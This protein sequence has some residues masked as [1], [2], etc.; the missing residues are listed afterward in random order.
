MPISTAPATIAVVE[1]AIAGARE[2]ADFVIFSIHWSPHMRER[3]TLE[4]RE[5]ARRI[6]DAGA[7]LVWGHGSHVVQ[8]IELWHGNPILY[9]TGDF[10]DDYAVDP[11]LRTD[12]SALF[13]VRVAPSA[14]ARIEVL[15]VR[16]ADGQVNRACGRDRNW[17]ARRF[18]A[19]CAEFGT[20]VVDD[21]DVLTVPV[22]E[23]RTGG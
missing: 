16:I 17:F 2:E 3:P 22:A 13:L 4:F 11:R 9:D 15:P 19:L 7:D 12:L 10:V 20:R 6:V 8:G 1:Q 23:S 5:F 21:G 14:I 18:M